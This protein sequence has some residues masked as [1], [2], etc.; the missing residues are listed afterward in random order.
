M[1]LLRSI[2]GPVA[3]L[4][5]IGP[6][7]SGKS[8]LLNQ[9]LGVPC[10]VG[11]GVGHTRDTQ[12]KGIWIWSQPRM[13]Q[14]PGGGS[15]AVLFIDTEGFE[16]TAR[17]NSYD[18]RIFAASTLLSSLLLYNLPEAVRQSDI[19]KLSFAVDLAQGF[20]ERFHVSG[21]AGLE[22]AWSGG[23]EW[24][25]AQGFYERFHDAGSTGSDF[26]PGSMLW[27][28][29][30]DF[31]QGKSADAL[32]REALALVPNPGK[33]KEVEAL[34]AIRG[35]LA[36]IAGNSTGVSLRQPHLERTKLCDLPDSALDQEY[37]KQRD[38]LRETVMSLSKPKV[39]AGKPVTGPQLAALLQQTV[40]ALN[41][42]EIPNVGLLIEAFNADLT[43]RAVQRR[44]EAF[45]A[46]LTQRA[47]Q[48]FIA[49]LAALELP[50]TEEALAE[51]AAQAKEAALQLFG[52]A[53]LGRKRGSHSKPSLLAQLER[54]VDVRAT[55]NAAASTKLCAALEVKCE[56]G[57]N[58]V[59]G[60]SLVVTAW[61]T[62]LCAALEAK[63]E[64]EL[65]SL[66]AMRLPSLRRFEGSYDRCART[67]SGECLGPARSEAEARLTH[68][69]ARAKGSF[70]QEYNGRLY[71]GLIGASIVGILLFRFALKIQ[72]LE[73]GCWLSFAFLQV[74]PHA[75][76]GSGTIYE[77]A[78][79]RWTVAVW[80]TAMLVLFGFDGAGVLWLCCLMA[81]VGWRLYRRR[82]LQRR[83]KR[84]GGPGVGSGGASGTLPKSGRRDLDV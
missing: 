28:I 23:L 65:D 12:T 67:F 25:L 11:F 62:K 48:G 2:T 69:W 5:V 3:P 60:S 14:M 55:Q 76:I 52:G 66:Q 29:Q 9:L 82:Q 46:D 81:Y 54:E 39:V 36:A 56:G 71:T 43:Q 47:V 38:A 84:Q 4:V 75:W 26:E 1:D 79:W 64:A 49:A 78:G 80:E 20:Y 59:R 18:D 31:L 61:S 34:N 22:W 13:K 27:V 17:A 68:A 63:C 45:G 73:A 41:T 8:F 50:V 30:R 32:V 10:D 15:V 72:V 21:W 24:Y 70:A 58:G 40:E 6:Y 33:D 42:Q 44:M 77:T 51:G 16:S 74:A 7:R 57:S 19:S 53:S 83:G 37:V 35:S